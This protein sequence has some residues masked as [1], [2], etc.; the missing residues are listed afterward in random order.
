MNL[1]VRDLIPKLLKIY[2]QATGSTVNL[3]INVLKEHGVDESDILLIC[4]FAT[5]SGLKSVMTQYPKINI[6][7]SEISTIVLNDFGRRYFGTE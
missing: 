3:A 1:S 6:L 5:P 4:L 2:I 7:T